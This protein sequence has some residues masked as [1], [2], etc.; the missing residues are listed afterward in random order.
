MV[1]RR[2]RATGALTACLVLGAVRAAGASPFDVFGFGPSG[3]ASVGARA[4]RACD[5]TASFY[6]PG[7]LALGEGYHL[8]LGVLGAVSALTAQGER[9]RISD[10]VGLTI[11][12]DGDIPLEGPLEGVLRAGYGGY[13]LSDSLMHLETPARIDPTFPYYANRTQRLVVL[14]ALAARVTRWLGVGVAANAFASLGGPVAL[15]KG[16]SGA[17]EARIDEEATT[18]LGVIVG[19]QASPTDYLRFGLVYREEFAVPIRTRSFSTV[20]SMPLLVD[21]S[22]GQA[23]FTPEEYVLAIAVMPAPP[24]E[25]ELDAAYERWGEYRGPSMRTRATLPGVALDPRRVPALFRD[26]W[27]LRAAATYRFALGRHELALDAGAGYEP[28]VLRAEQQGE[29]NLVDGRKVSFGAGVELILRQLLGERALHFGA[30]AQVQAVGSYFQAKQ[31]CRTSGACAPDEV[32]GEDALTPD[33]GIA[34][35][36]YPALSG[37]GRVWALTGAVGVDL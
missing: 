11:A 33:A 6:N 30:G 22:L 4:A 16:A 3:V 12:L 32:W 35:P 8:E 20:G 37:S 13:A 19:A 18:T 26:V 27:T 2:A 24:L 23:F 7:G 9:Q 29:T 17:L 21:V 36:G 28:S 10:P 34:N 1:A 25:L 5:G 14:P 15:S 31:V